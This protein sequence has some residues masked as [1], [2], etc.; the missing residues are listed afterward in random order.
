MD[1]FRE[2]AALHQFTSPGHISSA[3]KTGKERARVSMKVAAY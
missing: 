1:P 3:H 2:G